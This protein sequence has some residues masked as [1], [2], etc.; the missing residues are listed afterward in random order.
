MPWAS[1]YREREKILNTL[2]HKQER[3]K[4]A[5]WL[6]LLYWI[7]KSF[8]TQDSGGLQIGDYIFCVSFVCFFIE[9]VGNGEF[10][11]I[12]KKENLF[13]LFVCFVVAINLAYSIAYS[14]VGFLWAVAYF[15][16][17]FFVIIE[18]RY[19]ARQKSFLKGFFIATC[20][21]LLIQFVIYFSGK[22]RMFSDSRYMGTFND[23]NQL[24]FFVMS[25]FFIVYMIHCHM[26]DIVGKSKIWTFAAF[27]I[28]MF[29]VVQSASTGMLLGVGIF[30]VVWL[31]NFCRDRKHRLI[32]I[33]LLLVLL[34]VVFLGFGGDE[35]L[36]GDSF[37]SIRLQEKINK[38]TGDGG[39]QGYIKDRNLGAFF[40]KPYYVLFGAGE[41]Y[42]VRFADIDAAG[43]LHSTVISLLFCYG[44]IPFAILLSWIF[45]NI[46]H[47]KKLDFCIYIAIF[48]EML[49]L[50]NHRQSSL[51]ILFIL[52]S[53]LEKNKGE[54]I[55]CCFQ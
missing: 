2:I 31:F 48:I 1:D 15:A 47:S 16:F 11:L 30:I 34:G 41:G 20:M 54:L 32:V 10:S 26:C 7:A 5:G 49:T 23:P 37:I 33:I 9:T 3:V 19:L 53:I 29:L 51:W 50:V 44:I 38:M 6:F 22:G 28:T 55:E 21:C 35:I 36:F 18:F 25:R 43:E 39:V 13:F 42:W 40:Y 45:K 24:A 8:Y 12:L 52:P 14:N 4:I 27:L 46:S 17:N